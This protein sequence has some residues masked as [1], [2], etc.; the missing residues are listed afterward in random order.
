MT[1][2]MWETTVNYGSH[3]D[4]QWGCVCGV[5]LCQNS[6]T[7]LGV[8]HTSETT[9]AELYTRLTTWVGSDRQLRQAALKHFSFA[10]CVICQLVC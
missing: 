4:S 10:E 2:Q 8:S 3:D 1:L 5:H 9:C 6:T 7:V